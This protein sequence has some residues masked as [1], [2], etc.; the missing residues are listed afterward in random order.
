MP[1]RDWLELEMNSRDIR[2][3][4]VS[5]HPIYRDSDWR[6]DLYQPDKVDIRTPHHIAYVELAHDLIYD[7]IVDAHDAFQ[8]F[9]DY[10]MLATTARRR[11]QF[12]PELGE[13]EYIYN[14]TLYF[15]GRNDEIVLAAYIDK[16]GRKTKNRN[17]LH[18]EL[19]FR[20]AQTCKRIGIHTIGDLPEYDIPA[21]FHKRVELAYFEPI[22][23]GR[24]IRAKLQ[25]G[26]QDSYPD[27]RIGGGLMRIGSSHDIIQ[28]IQLAGMSA[29]RQKI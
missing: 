29:I 13:D 26:L 6:I 28:H 11:K 23:L 15:G 21:M 17:A 20:N 18:L 10:G 7:D 12:F 3:A 16:H 27:R 5:R 9:S 2:R 1:Y 14:S 25:T 8:H 22:S 19:R 4:F 24:L